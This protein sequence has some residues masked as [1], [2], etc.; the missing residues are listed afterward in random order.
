MDE[1]RPSHR[2]VTPRVLPFLVSNKP[3]EQVRFIIL[4]PP[5]DLGQRH[6]THASPRTQYMPRLWPSPPK[7]VTVGALWLE[8]PTTIDDKEKAAAGV[9]ASEPVPALKPTEPT[10]TYKWANCRRLSSVKE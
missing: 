3:V 9:T 4:C 2:D 8:P 6:I 10:K 5:L 1:Q 7:Y